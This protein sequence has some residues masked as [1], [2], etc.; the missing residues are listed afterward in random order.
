MPKM[1]P[2]GIQILKKWRSPTCFGGAD[3]L[4]VITYIIFIITVM[5]ITYLSFLEWQVDIPWL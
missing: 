2:S 5:L 3:L 4:L 1:A